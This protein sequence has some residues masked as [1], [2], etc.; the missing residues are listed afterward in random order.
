MLT[1]SAARAEELR[2]EAIA[3]RKLQGIP[4]L[5]P[6][7][8]RLGSDPEL[9]LKEQV[10]RNFAAWGE[11]KGPQGAAG[12]AAQALQ[13]NVER[14]GSTIRFYNWAMDELSPERLDAARAKLSPADYD[15]H[16]QHWRDEAESRGTALQSLRDQL[17]QTYQVNGT[18]FEEQPDGRLSLGQFS[19]A[20]SG[21]DYTAQVDQFGHAAVSVKGG[22]FTDSFPRTAQLPGYYGSG[23][24]AHLDVSV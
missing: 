3:N 17:G 16:V 5:R 6:L 9:T 13:S 21:D 7:S 24:P 15:K 20:F 8:K 14:F 11:T 22:A 10:K 4:E 12:A 1:I 18:L 19:V 23:K 2:L